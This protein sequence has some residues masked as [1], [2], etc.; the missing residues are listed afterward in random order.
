[1]R[2]WACRFLCMGH[3]KQLARRSPDLVVM[4]SFE[5]F[6]SCSFLG[7]VLLSSHDALISTW[8]VIRTPSCTCFALSEDLPSQCEQHLQCPTL[9]CLRAPAGRCVLQLC[10][11]RAPVMRV[12]APVMRVSASFRTSGSATLKSLK[13][14]VLH[15]ISYNYAVAYLYSVT[16]VAWNT[17]R[18]FGAARRQVA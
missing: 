2:R 3:A 6:A 13:F 10:T 8:L 18:A 1:M 12:R 7:S 17:A 15:V 16:C 4:S 9:L 5:G 11:V 14:V